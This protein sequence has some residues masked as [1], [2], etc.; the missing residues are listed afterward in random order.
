MPEA[1][2][3]FGYALTHHIRLTFGYTLLYWSNV[4]R[5]GDQIDRGLNPSELAAVF[6]R[7]PSTGA[8]RPTY[9]FQSTDFWAQGL[10]F[11]LQFRY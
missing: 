4:F 9:T 10:N 1:G 3:N 11:G 6:G 5:A 8:A 2:I 7:G